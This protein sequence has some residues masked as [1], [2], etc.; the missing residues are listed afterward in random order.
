M[1]V[2]FIS[3]LRHMILLC[4]VHALTGLKLAH[5]QT[6][7][8]GSPFNP[9]P[10]LQ[11]ILPSASF[12]QSDSA[13]N[14]YM[15]QTFVYLTWPAFPGK[16]GQP[17]AKAPYGKAGATV[18]ETFRQYDTVFLPN[19]KKPLAWNS[20]TF[21]RALK[22]PRV[23]KNT[24]KMFRALNTQE[25]TLLSETQ[26]AGGGILIDQ[27]GQTVYYEMSMNETEFNYIVTNTLYEATQQNNFAKNTGIVLPP[28]SIEI[29]AAWKVLS[30]QEASAKP[31]I[32]H[33]TQAILPNQPKPVTMGLV[34]LHIMVVP[35]AN[36]FN[37]GFWAT[38]QHT[39]NAP[40]ANSNN[41][42]GQ[43]SFYNP[44]CSAAN[45]PVNVQTKA[46]T[47]TQVQQVF[48]A[49]PEAKAVNNYMAQLIASS[50]T[51]DAVWKNYELID[52][53]WPTSPQSI[54][55]AGKLAPLPNGTPN[56][57]TLM[58][59]VLETFIQRQNMSCLTCH[60]GA[61]TAQ[62]TGFPGYASSYSF[63]LG[64]AKSSQ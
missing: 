28:N 60:T 20:G 23:L 22:K 49:T 12:S 13:V 10:V 33:T 16:A 41:T 24:S 42:T 55:G 29:K 58:N 61:A 18:W 51:P 7:V 14:C 34:G 50:S 2:F 62:V 30:P 53:Q 32:F 26:Q 6:A 11:P 37:Q 44:A 19:G 25:S 5:A 57:N 43:Y 3:A 15:W 9:A 39:N 48:D 64:H 31:Q 35:S 8:C 1:K 56:T 36:N 4:V 45:C 59:P 38:F 52:V 54:Q 21:V 63:L 17:N 27:N 40:L 47:P 46:P